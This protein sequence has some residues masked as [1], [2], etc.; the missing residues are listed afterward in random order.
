MCVS[1]TPSLRAEK[2]AFLCSHRTY[3]P[4]DVRSKY[5]YCCCCCVL[6]RPRWLFLVFLHNIDYIDYIHSRRFAVYTRFACTVSW[7]LQG[8][9]SLSESRC[10][11]HGYLVFL[12]VSSVNVSP[13]THAQPRKTGRVPITYVPPL[14]LQH[15]PPVGHILLGA[16]WLTIRCI[17]H[18]PMQVCNKQEKS[19]RLGVPSTGQDHP[20]PDVGEVQPGRDRHGRSS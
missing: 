11:L 17:R 7:W 10:V 12:V 5:V 19:H 20:S 18:T 1:S 16:G 4:C 8:G 14:F 2:G 13:A 15:P 3:I 6:V 9:G